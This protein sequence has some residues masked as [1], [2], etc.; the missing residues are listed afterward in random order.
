[1]TIVKHSSLPSALNLCLHVFPARGRFL[2][3]S[4]AG[5]GL[6]SALARPLVRCSHSAWLR[7]SDPTWVQPWRG[8]SKAH[9]WPSRGRSGA[10]LSFSGRP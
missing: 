5:S 2:P 4:V 9:S 7:C 1:M 6:A 3:S 8:T 10:H